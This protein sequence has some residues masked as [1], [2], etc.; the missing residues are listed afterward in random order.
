M[1][2]SL[3]LLIFM[4]LFLF[5]CNNT[6]TK[7]ITNNGLIF[8]TY[9]HII[10]ES[11]KGIDLQSEIDTELQ[12]LNMSLSTYNEKSVLSKVNI[13]EPVEL[14]SLF[15]NVFKR[16]M[17]IAEQTK[18]AFD[19]TVAPLVNAWGFGFRKKENITQQLIDSIKQFVGYHKININ[20][21]QI[22]K[23]DKRIMLDFSAIAKGYSVDVIGL[24]LE[25]IG[26]NNY[27]VE[28]GGEVV[29]KGLNKNGLNWR[30]GIN[31]PKEDE[32]GVSTDLQAIVGLNNKAL[33]TSGN[34]RNFYYEKGKKFAHTIDPLKGYPVE[35]SLLSATVMANDCMTADAF[36]TAFMVMGLKKAQ[37]LITEYSEIDIF[38]IYAN[39]NGENQI[40]MT[41]GFKKY[42]IYD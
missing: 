8:G 25:N 13:N 42:I 7:Y 19:P 36:A 37:E 23:D 11:P 15:I 39:E 40:L 14:D 20:N 26:C 38:L 31:Q 16:S 35:H 12:R 28:I 32:A 34:Y 24:L 17:Q 30:I 33:A 4:L 1:K 22:E 21:R 29:A 2:Q 6:K 3:F 9:Y 5:S 10:Y 18:G 27:M 41:E